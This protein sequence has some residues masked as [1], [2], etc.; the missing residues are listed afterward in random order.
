MMSADHVS[1]GHY[2]AILPDHRSSSPETCSKW[3]MLL[4]IIALPYYFTIPQPEWI[5]AAFLISI[6]I[7][8][9]CFSSLGNQ[10]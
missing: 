3:I 5:S 6:W 9:L 10:S 2:Q 4:G 7:L 1:R 8:K